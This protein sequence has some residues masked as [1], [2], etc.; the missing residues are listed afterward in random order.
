MKGNLFVKSISSGLTLTFYSVVVLLLLRIMPDNFFLNQLKLRGLIYQTSDQDKLQELLTSNQPITFYWGTDVTAKSFHL[1][2]LV[3]FNLIRSL[4]KMGHKPIILLGGGT[5]LIGDPSGREKS[6]PILSEEEIQKNTAAL[7][8]QLARFVQFDQLD[9]SVKTA[10]I[11]N[12]IE[13]LGKIDL[14]R[15]YLREFA[16]FFN[17]NEMISWETWKNRLKNNEG[18]SLMEFV[19]NTLQAIDFYFL[20]QNYGCVMQVGGS[21]QWLNLL[22]GVDLIR[23]KSNVE[24]LA[25]STPL[26]LDREGRKMGKTGEGKTVWL[27]EKLFSPYEMYQYLRNRSDEEVE[28]MLK[29]LTPLELSE[30]VEIMKQG[31]VARLERLAFEITALVHGV[32]KA[33]KAQDDSRSAFGGKIS[34]SESS[35]TV[36]I[37]KKD[38]GSEKTS[39]TSLLTDSRLISSKS[40]V[41][42]LIEAGGIR[43]NNQKVES[44]DF[45]LQESNLKDGLA[46]LEIGKRK[47]VKVILV[48]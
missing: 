11:V 36:E 5:T 40:E 41:R 8:N 3:S 17:V 43:L 42:R 35:P 1:G 21:D 6:R 20:N 14:M 27:D 4:Q 34:Q 46:I 16:P 31:P 25:V 7:K 22:S 13:W 26:L 10:T 45:V 30:I 12:N 33:Q 48:S 29:L 2:H 44:A 15:G 9:K 37:K 47:V 38:L 24:A 32:E 18:I 28:T 19:Y 23:K 39:L